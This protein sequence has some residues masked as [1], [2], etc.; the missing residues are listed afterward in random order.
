MYKYILDIAHIENVI[1][2]FLEFVSQQPE[3]QGMKPSFTNGYLWKSEGYKLSTFVHGTDKLLPQRWN[4]KAIASGAVAEMAIKAMGIQANNF[5]DRFQKTSFMNKLT[6]KPQEGGEILFRFYRNIIDDRSSLEEFA[7]FF[8]RRY[9][10]ISYLFY[11]KDPDHNLPCKPNLF[12]G[13]FQSLGIRTECFASC[14]YD[15][16]M[17]FNAALRELADLYSRYAEHISVLAAHSFAWIISQYPEVKSYIFEGERL[18]LLD[19][20]KKQERQANV[21][22]RVNQTEFRKNLIDFWSGKCCITGCKQTDILIASHIKPWRSCELN[23]E[24]VDAFN[25]LL[26]VPN[27]DRLFDAG[28]ISFQDDG[29]IMLSPY[30]SPEDASILGV[31]KG[32][33][34]PGLQ[35]QHHK[36]LEFHRNNVFKK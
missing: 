30:L 12:R 36:Y 7:G 5:V 21:K 29:T 16:Y 14:T 26:L 4:Q 10:I 13:A 6:E 25:G 33:R 32:I 8:G 17:A 9:D 15:N 3:Q 19:N 2:L 20:K 28:Y 27:L 11:L 24:C 1:D 18:E 34:I 22:V 23:S 31:S 35:K